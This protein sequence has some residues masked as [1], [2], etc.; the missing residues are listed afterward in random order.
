MM[1]QYRVIIGK[2]CTTL[3]GNIDNGGGYAR[4]GVGGI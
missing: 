2:K 1:C 3:E 4:I